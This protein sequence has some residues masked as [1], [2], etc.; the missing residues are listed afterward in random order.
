MVFDSLLRSTLTMNALCSCFSTI[1]FRCNQN[2]VVSFF[3]YIYIYSFYHVVYK[4]AF[5]GLILE[6]IEC[7]C[8]NSV[9]N[10]M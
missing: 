8:N 6:V 7:P 9:G 1:S 4:S 5:A 3:I 2:I 10:K